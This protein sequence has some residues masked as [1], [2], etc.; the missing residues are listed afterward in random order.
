M[1]N[2]GSGP[3]SLYP[4][5]VKSDTEFNLISDFL[6]EYMAA[7]KDGS[8]EPRLAEK[9]EERDNTIWTFHLRPGIKWSNGE[10]IPVE[11]VVWSWQRLADSKT[12]S[13]YASH[14][15]LPLCFSPVSEIFCRWIRAKQPRFL[16][17]QR[18]VH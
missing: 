3:A 7:R 5:K 1:C 4:H 16:L 10:S 17:P 9:W 13:P 15:C 14:S 8:M 6:D 18:D 12:A 11:D 2:N